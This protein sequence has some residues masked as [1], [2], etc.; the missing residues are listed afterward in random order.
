[1]QVQGSRKPN[2]HISGKL[3]TSNFNH[4]GEHNSHTSDFTHPT[5]FYHSTIRSC[6][7]PCNKIFGNL[8][9]YID[10]KVAFFSSAE[11]LARSEKR[12]PKKEERNF[13]IY[14]RIR[15]FKQFAIKIKCTFE[16]YTSMSDCHF[17]YEVISLR[18]VLY[19]VAEIVFFFLLYFACV[20][21]TYYTNSDTHITE[22]RVVKSSFFVRV[23]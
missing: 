18:I 2:L 1:M 20:S 14:E 12:K 7:T 3:A 13:Q 15:I 4:L 5:P 6:R 22:H 19:R 10:L 16:S 8:F 21:E 11:G 17:K 9:K 23:F